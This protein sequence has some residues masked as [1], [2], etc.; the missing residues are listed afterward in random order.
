[1][2]DYTF[3]SQ[4]FLIEGY[5]IPFRLD[6]NSR[7]G[8][9]IIYVREDI[10][11][12]ELSY[13]PFENNVEGIFLEVNLRKTK[14][15]VFGGYNYNKSNIDHFLGN[16]GPIL[17]HFM[18]TYDNVLLMG[19][20]N[21]ETK[22]ISMAEF[23]GIYSI[24]NLIT[25]PT[26]FKNPLHPTSIDVM[27]TNKIRSFQNNQTIDTGLSDYHKMTI[28]VLKTFFQ[29]QDPVTINYRDYKSFDKSKF[30]FELK[31][32]LDRYIHI[33]SIMMFLNLLL[34]IY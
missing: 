1:M 17:D 8:G 21:S 22:E 15:L 2:L 30:H 12:R 33:I 28:T 25:A 31:N 10:P 29:K 7:S 34:W 14:W 23:C 5:A 3:P 32:A 24:Q 11:C 18:S 9:V 27:L 4:Q 13:R 6:K 19:D 16:L 26:C 20:F